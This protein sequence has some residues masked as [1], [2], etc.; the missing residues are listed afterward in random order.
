MSASGAHLKRGLN[1]AYADTAAKRIIADARTGNVAFVTAI[2]SHCVGLTRT[3]L[4]TVV[5]V[6]FEALAAQHTR[7]TGRR[8]KPAARQHDSR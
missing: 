6:L 5:Q 2:E 7:P 1:A 4:V 8:S 3:Q